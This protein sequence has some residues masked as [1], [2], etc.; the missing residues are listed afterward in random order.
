MHTTNWNK[1]LTDP[2]TYKSSWDWTVSNSEY[3][4]DN[5]RQD[6]EG[7]WFKILGRFPNPESW[8]QEMQTIIDESKAISWETRKYFGDYDD[9][10]PMLE[11][12]E[13]DIIQGHGDPK[14]ELS[15]ML[16]DFSN[17]PVLKSMCDYF[18]LTESTDLSEG[19]KKK[20]RSHV[21]HTGQMFNRHIDKLWDWKPSD[22]EQICR[23]SIFL[24][25]WEPG[26]FYQYGTYTYTNWKAGDCHTFDWANVP[27][28]TANASN[29]LRT[30]LL[31]TGL[32]TDRTR[33]IIESGNASNIFIV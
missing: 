8:Q 20:Y 32:K 21:Q 33:E 14:L 31:L 29:T 6:K 2:A 11:Q 5:E 12:E 18:A 26:Q 16:D 27:H 7:E 22:P 13:Y 15:N 25:D 1:K 17:L 19:L 9:V 10:S 30:T 24:T 28:A 4:F 3:H 23:I